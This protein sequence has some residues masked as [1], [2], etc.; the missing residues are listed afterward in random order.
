[1]HILVIIEHERQAMDNWK[2]P[3]AIY[4]KIARE[5]RKTWSDAQAPHNIF[6]WNF[7]KE[8]LEILYF[9][10][11]GFF[12]LTWLKFKIFLQKEIE[13]HIV[14]HPYKILR[15]IIILTWFLNCQSRITKGNVENIFKEKGQKLMIWSIKPKY[16]FEVIN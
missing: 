4:R 6:V 13:K 14:Q 5:V 15:G 12:S 16:N 2:Q 11:K 7:L 1:M 9:C 10:K 3:E 8:L